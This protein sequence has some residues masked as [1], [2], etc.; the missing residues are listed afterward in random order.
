[1]SGSDI[2][3]ARQAFERVYGMQQQ[4][5]TQYRDAAT[6]VEEQRALV[7]AL[8]AVVKLSKMVDEANE[9]GRIAG[10]MQASV[11][12]T[13]NAYDAFKH[14]KLSAVPSEGE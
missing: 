12:A 13:W 2:L 7:D 5:I 6:A 14:P 4:A 3:E 11:T 8:E 10:N 1:M 9:L